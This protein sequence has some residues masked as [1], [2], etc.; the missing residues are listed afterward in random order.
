MRESNEEKLRQMWQKR[1][2][3]QRKNMTKQKRYG[4]RQKAKARKKLEV[5]KSDVS[6]ERTRKH[7]ASMKVKVNFKKTPLRSP[8]KKRK[9]RLGEQLSLLERE[10]RI[11]FKV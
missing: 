10:E 11:D 3:N 5:E 8:L 9:K 2:E 6:T 4:V 1:K 7:R